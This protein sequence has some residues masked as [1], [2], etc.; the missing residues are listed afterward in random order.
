MRDNNRGYSLVELI[1][2]IAILAIV[3][4]TLT[5]ILP[6]NG[7]KV[8]E[9]ATTIEGALKETRTDVLSRESAYMT[10]GMDASGKKYEISIS[11]KNKVYVGDSG[12][13]IRVYYQMEDGTVPST[14]YFDIDTGHQLILS[15]NRASGAFRPMISTVNGDGSVTY[16]EC[17]E[18]G[19]TQNCY[20][21]KIE[22]SRG[23]KT[24]NVNLVRDTGKAYLDE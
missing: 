14:N 23:S 11:G 18:S 15:Y 10:L 4:G 20:C 21:T 1:V 6:M 3:A 24:M 19:V 22:V 12:T 2:V 13:T 8:K 16:V 9:C 5:V 17:T 7:P